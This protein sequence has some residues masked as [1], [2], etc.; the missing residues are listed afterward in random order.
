MAT[1]SELAELRAE[2][3]TKSE[4]AELRADVAAHRAETKSGFEELD[5]DLNGPM[6]VHRKLEK[7]I[8][9]LK[10]QPPRTTARPARRR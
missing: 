1:K 8:E 9:A 3:A 5:K 4:L 6:D 2:M 7:D 10:R